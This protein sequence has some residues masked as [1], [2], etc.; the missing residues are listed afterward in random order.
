MIEEKINYS[1][2]GLKAGLEIHQQIDSHKLFCD[3]VSILRNDEPKFSVRRKLHAIAGESG[4]IDEAVKHEATMNKEFVYHGYDTTCLVELDEE[5]PHAL[6]QEALKT[7]MEIAMLLN[8][9]IVPI[10]QIMRKTVIDGSNT[11]GFQ[12]TVLI[13]EDGFIETSLGKVGIAAVML[14]EDSARPFGN[15]NEGENKN[16]IDKNETNQNQIDEAGFENSKSYKI[17]RLGLPLVEIATKPDLKT[18]E[19]IKEAALKIGE[20]I[21]ASKVRRGIGTIRQDLNIS[22]AGSKR[23][24]IKGFQDPKIMIRTVELEILRQNECLEKNSCKSEVRKTNPDGTTVFM[25]PMPG[26]ARMYPETDVPML[27]ISREMID[28]VKKNLPKLNSDSRE[29]LR[30]H[31]LNDE[32]IKLIMSCGMEKVLEFKNLIQILDKPDLIVKMIC[33]YPR[34]IA[35]KEGKSLEATE[36]IFGNSYESI[37]DL[38]KKGKISEGDVKEILTKLAKGEEF[39]DAVK[40][41]KQDMK[42][43]EEMI[44]RIIKDKPGLRANAYMGLAMAEASRTGSK[45]DAKRTME[46]INGFLESKK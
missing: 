16:Q 17:D 37:L 42:G 35:S 29:E 15:K 1:K 14:E 32:M 12:R 19:Q 46:I 18:P 9:E 30:K 23:V 25:R 5:P 43:A 22:I 21:R 45:L 27:K 8:C 38:L 2:L 3:C 44:L 41:K 39:S 7:A 28:S 20:I 36:E 4:E 33:L 26:A 31:G 40:I 6:N 10:A 34:E 24:E 11:S 13:A